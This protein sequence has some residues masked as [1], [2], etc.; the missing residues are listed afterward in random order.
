MPRIILL[1]CLAC[2]YPLLSTA[3][4]RP[5]PTRVIL[6]KAQLPAAQG[7]EKARLLNLI[8]RWYIDNGYFSACL[9]RI[10]RHVAFRIQEI[11]RL[12]T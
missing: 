4:L 8:A 2:F 1:L 5:E 6:M 11:D 10:Y 7:E 12:K 3:Q 9:Q